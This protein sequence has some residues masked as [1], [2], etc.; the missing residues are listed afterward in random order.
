MSFMGRLASRLKFY[1]FFFLAPLYLALPAFL[2]RL[3]EYRYLWILSTILI[4]A[5]GTNLYPYFFSHYVA[6]IACLFVLVIVTSLEKIASLETIG[7]EAASILMLVCA[8]H[9]VFWYGLHFA[10]N[11]DFAHD[12]WQ[13]ETE[14]VITAGDPQGRVAIHDR[15]ISAPGAQLVFVRYGPAH[16][17]EEWV[18]NRADIDSSRIVWARDLGGDENEKLRHYYPG[19]TAW[20]LQPD[21]HPPLLTPYIPLPASPAMETVAP[22]PA[23]KDPKRPKP[24]LRFEDVPDK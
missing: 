22:E 11:Q 12:M 6:A 19:R 3:R 10:G 8:A 18:Y 17:F 20:L 23:V 21:V 24:P 7:P 4:F 9:F 1:R 15:L 14:D 13:F 5:L 2:L 16:V